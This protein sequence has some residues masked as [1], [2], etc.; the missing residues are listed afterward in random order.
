MMLSQMWILPEFSLTPKLPKQV[1][2]TTG[3]QY[4]Q[5]TIIDTS[6]RYNNA[7]SYNQ[8]SRKRT[9]SESRKSV[10]N[11]SWPLTGMIFS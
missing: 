10:R 6:F 2:Q 5:L 9:P 7:K 4:L 8:S 3:I 1:S 11:W